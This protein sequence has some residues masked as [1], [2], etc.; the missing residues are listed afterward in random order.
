MKKIIFALIA[1]VMLCTPIFA[2]EEV[3]ETTTNTVTE[4]AVEV[5]EGESTVDVDGIID[6]I[7]SSTMW[8]TI[9]TVGGSVLAIVS[10][11]AKKFGHI[12]ELIKSKA[13]TKTVIEEFKNGYTELNTNISEELDKIKAALIASEDNNKTLIAALSIFMVSA[14]IS[15]PAKNEIL[16]CLHG[17]KTVSGNVDEY[18]DNA[19]KIISEAEALEEKPSTPIL[20]EI[21]ETHI[22]LG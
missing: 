16:K 11:V 9:A 2:T 17:I 6:K 5:T 1:L 19:I 7:S 18:I 10:V 4:T 8:I 15:T 20:D 13:D 22:A 21:S 14:K 3:T 12:F